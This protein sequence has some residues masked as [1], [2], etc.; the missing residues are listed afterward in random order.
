MFQFLKST[1]S[2]YLVW[3][4]MNVI[5]F[6]LGSLHGATTDGFIPTVVPGMTGLVMGDLVF[7]GMVGASQYFALYRTR[8]LPVTAGWI[9]A[10]ALGFTLGAR[11]GSLFTFRLTQDWTLAGILFGVFMGSSIGLT[12]ALLLFRKISPLYL[13]TWFGVCVAAWVAGESIAFSVQFS[14][15]YVPL[16]ALTIAGITGLGLMILHPHLNRH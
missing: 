6:V 8:F 16:V 1:L 15:Y 14:M 12:T 10:T 11:G 9:L 2:F 3:L 7:G 5:G 4:V 13:L